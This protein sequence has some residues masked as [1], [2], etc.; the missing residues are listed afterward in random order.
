MVTCMVQASLQGKDDVIG[1]NYGAKLVGED[2]IGGIV[3][4][5]GAHVDE[6]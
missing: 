6:L 3:E 4:A 1:D 5:E 2:T